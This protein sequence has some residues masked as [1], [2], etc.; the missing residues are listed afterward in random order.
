MN[1]R[2]RSQD[3]KEKKEGKNEQTG[4]S[5]FDWRNAKKE[6]KRERE[7]KSYKK[8]LILPFPTAMPQPHV[9]VLTVAW[10]QQVKVKVKL[11]VESESGTGGAQYTN[12]A[13]TSDSN[14]ENMKSESGK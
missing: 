5:Y 7:D 3:P 11:K 9:K 10:G 6:I 4:I 8:R 13:H 12:K 2:R 1:S 14:S